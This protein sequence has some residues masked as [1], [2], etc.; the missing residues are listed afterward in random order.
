MMCN[1]TASLWPRASNEGMVDAVSEWLDRRRGWGVVAVR[2][3]FGFWLVYGTQDNV[4][5]RARMVEF[6]DFIA[7]HGFAFPVAGAYVSAYAQFICGFMY[8]AGASVRTAGALMAVN[9]LFALAI[10]HR[11]T[12]IAADLPAWGML[13]VAVLLLFHGAGPLSV[14]AAWQRRR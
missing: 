7:K 8:M 14:D 12:P 11:S 5:S 1:P 9:F 13:A 10:A 6:Q 2:V 4:F 3:A